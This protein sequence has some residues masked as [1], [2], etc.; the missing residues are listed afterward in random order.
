MSEC[1]QL[2]FHRNVNIMVLLPAH[3]IDASLRQIWPTTHLLQVGRHNVLVIRKQ[4]IPAQSQ[5]ASKGF[6]A[7]GGATL[8]CRCGS[9]GRGTGG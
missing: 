4:S 8:V 5:N 2:K 9:K 1:L 6:A 3:T 7:I